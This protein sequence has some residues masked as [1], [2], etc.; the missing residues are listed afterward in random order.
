MVSGQPGQPGGEA[1]HLRPVLPAAELAAVQA[2]HEQQQRAGVGLHRA[3]DVTE[4]HQAAWP[5][6]GGP[7]GEP[8]RLAAA[9]PRLAQRRAQVEP[10]PLAGA[11]VPAGAPDR[12]G[13]R[14]LAHERD[15]LPQL[16]RGQLDEIAAA[17]PLGGRGRP[18]QGRRS[19]RRVIAV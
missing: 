5:D 10:L 18:V 17:Q 16:G 2:V 19:G 15:K 11:P 14:H 13:Q 1:E 7:A 8:D 4:D 12:H 9:A 3:G 6:P